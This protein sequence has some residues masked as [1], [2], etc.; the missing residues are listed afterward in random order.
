MKTRYEVYRQDVFAGAEPPSDE[1]E[2][3]G[4]WEPFHAQCDVVA[5]FVGPAVVCEIVWWRRAREQES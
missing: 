5:D 1:D 3:A 2:N 4:P